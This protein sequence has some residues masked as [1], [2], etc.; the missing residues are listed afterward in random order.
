MNCKVWVNIALM[1]SDKQ[2]LEQ[3]LAA[4]QALNLGAFYHIYKE[5]A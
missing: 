5:F 3:R 4:I 2:T 1:K